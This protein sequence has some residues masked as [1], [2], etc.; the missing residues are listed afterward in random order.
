MG[1]LPTGPEING[2]DGETHPTSYLSARRSYEICKRRLKFGL[3]ADGAEQVL[4]S[5]CADSASPIKLGV[6]RFS[7]NCPYSQSTIGASDCHPRPAF[8]SHI[9]N[10][11]FEAPMYTADALRNHNGG[12]SAPDRHRQANR[13][14]TVPLHHRRRLDQRH[15]VDGLRLN[16]A[17]PDAEQPVR[18]EMRDLGVAASGRP[19]D[20]A[21]RSPQA[22]ARRGSECSDASCRSSG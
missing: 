1:S 9:W 13:T 8:S 12:L 3:G 4:G 14:P 7:T 18:E 2:Q 22:S 19:V 10:N 21:G 15:G 6:D 20:G 17:E 5:N 16:W 11:V